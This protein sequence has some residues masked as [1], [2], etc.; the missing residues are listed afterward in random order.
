MN[1]TQYTMIPVNSSAIR[2]VGYDV[3]TLIL[4]V[5]FHTGKV[6]DHPGV[7][8]WVYDGLMRAP[9]KGAYYS[10]YIRGKYK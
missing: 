5:E 10:R 1:Q 4:S 2:A 6:Y 7:P 3:Y 8:H 9:S